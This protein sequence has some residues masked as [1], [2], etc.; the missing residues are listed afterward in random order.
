MSR[1]VNW[2]MRCQTFSTCNVDASRIGDAGWSGEPCQFVEAG[3]LLDG[4]FSET[5]LTG[6]NWVLVGLWP[7][8][9]AAGNGREMIAIDERA[10]HDQREALRQILLGEVGEVGTNHFSVVTNRCRDVFDPIYVPIQLE[11]DVDA[12]CGNLDVL[13]LVRVKSEQAK[14]HA[15]SEPFHIALTRPTC[16]M[17]FAYEAVGSGR[18]WVS[19][20]WATKLSG[21][22]AQFCIHHYDQDGFVAI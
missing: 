2:S 6:L 10:S 19:G 9:I 3:Y 11:L 5:P 21:A 18:A 13:N 22:Y 1:S 8:A 7:G 15:S 20:K 16:A 4:H 17:A 14:A 12:C